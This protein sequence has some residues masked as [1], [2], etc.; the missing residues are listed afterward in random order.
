MLT[1]VGVWS[2]TD[3]YNNL[4]ESEDVMAAIGIT[5]ISTPIGGVSWELKDS[6]KD[7]AKLL[8][9]FMEDKNMKL[10]VRNAFQFLLPFLLLAWCGNAFADVTTTEIIG[11]VTY[12]NGA[13]DTEFVIDDTVRVTFTIDD[14]FADSNA[15]A[16]TGIYPIDTLD[17]L[18]VEFEANG[19]RFE[20]QGGPGIF[21]SV[22]VRNDIDQGNNQFSDQLG[23]LGWTPNYGS[24][25]G[26][27]LSAM[28][29]DFAQDTLGI[30]PTMLINDGL[31]TGV[32]SFQSGWV[33]LKVDDGT[34]D[35]ME[36]MFSE[37]PLIDTDN[38]GMLDSCAP[39]DGDNDG[40]PDATDICP[41][42][43]NPNQGDTDGDGI[44]DACDN[45]ADNDGF[46][47][48]IDCNDLDS[49]IN[50]DSCDIKG[51]GID[52]DCDGTDRK[53]GKPCFVNKGGKNLKK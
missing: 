51:D 24:L 49:S 9:L 31:P 18:A 36:I 28:E 37:C 50:P 2:Y 33:L 53:K 43:Y 35:W 14:S 38:D 3:L 5:G 21:A 1:E 26:N 46:T 19:L 41:N 6:E 29:I 15:S 4:L 10:L 52:Q 20:A 27:L 42:D 16:N 48:N 12:I 22:T 30:A 44:G 32:L 39:L 8:I 34:S 13:Y 45:D 17:L 25:G 23:F 40:V 47:D 11:R 7:V